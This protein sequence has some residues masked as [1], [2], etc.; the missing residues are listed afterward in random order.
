[1]EKEKKRMQASEYV[2]Y[3]D[4]NHSLFSL[5]ILTLCKQFNFLFSILNIHIYLFFTLAV[6][7][8]V[9]IHQHTCMYMY[10]G[11]WYITVCGIVV[12]GNCHV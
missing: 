4:G 1:M 10:V 7:L 11:L 5:N 2:G 8:F 12:Y 3:S 9:I 6:H